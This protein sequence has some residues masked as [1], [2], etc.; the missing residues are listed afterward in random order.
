MITLKNSVIEVAIDEA[1]LAVSVTGHRGGAH[2]ETPGAGFHPHAIRG[3]GAMPARQA[4]VSSVLEKT[5][6]FIQNMVEARDAIKTV[7]HQARSI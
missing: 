2:W 4:F 5:S 1:N 7:F 6:G 3:L